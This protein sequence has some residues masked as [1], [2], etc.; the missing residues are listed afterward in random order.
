MSSVLLLLKERYSAQ[1]R[2]LKVKYTDCSRKYLET[3][4]ERM[5]NEVVQINKALARGY[6]TIHT[7]LIVNK[8]DYELKVK[9]KH[10]AKPGEKKYKPKK[11]SHKEKVSY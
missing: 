9:I 2:C 1:R 7:E 5:H 6:Y 3:K 10:H 11:N 8:K 4:A